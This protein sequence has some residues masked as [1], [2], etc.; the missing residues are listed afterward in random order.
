MLVVV[1]ELKRKR[2]KGQRKVRVVTFCVVVVVVVVEGE[3]WVCW[4]V[5]V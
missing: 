5:T 4:G 2:T 3:E 1:R